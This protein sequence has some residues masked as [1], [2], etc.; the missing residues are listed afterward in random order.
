MTAIEPFPEQLRSVM[1]DGDAD[2]ITVRQ[3][4]VQEVPADE[5]ADLHAGDVL[6]VDSTHVAKIGSDV[7]HLV[8]DVF[9]RLPPGVLVHVHDIA[10]PFE[11]PQEW[12]EEG[13]A[14]NEAYLLRAFCSKT[15]GGASRS[16][17]RCCG[18]VSRADAPGSTRARWWTAA[19]SGW[20][21]SDAAVTAVSPPAG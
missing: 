11:Y 12:V 1:R 21:R 18:C 8:F 4:K 20:R 10:Y 15:R 6:F 3:H 7:N 5:L 17:P 14:W 13:R 16:G 2:R 9:P 19:A